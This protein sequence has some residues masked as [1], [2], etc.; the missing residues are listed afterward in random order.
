MNKGI[1]YFIFYFLLSL[2]IK[3]KTRK[4]SSSQ[5]RIKRVKEAIH[6]GTYTCVVDNHVDPPILSSATLGKIH[7]DHD[8]INLVCLIAFLVKLYSLS[9]VPIPPSHISSPPAK[10]VLAIKFEERF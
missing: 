4:K 8:L 2:F 9:V 1:F 5:L 3:R 7:D 10:C 6:E